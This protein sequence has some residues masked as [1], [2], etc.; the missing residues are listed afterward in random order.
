L[1]YIWYSTDSL[2]LHSVLEEITKEDPPLK[3]Y[4]SMPNPVLPSDHSSLLAK[5][6]HS[7]P[8]L[9]QQQ[10]EGESKQQKVYVPVSSF[11]QLI[12]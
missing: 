3:T 11:P 5:F 4:G 9:Q 8:Q 6:C 12:R 2:Q 1:D 7:S 10:Q